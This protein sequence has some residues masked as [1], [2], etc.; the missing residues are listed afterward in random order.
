M[1]QLLLLNYLYLV[2]FYSQFIVRFIQEQFIRQEHDWI[3][4]NLNDQ[5]SSFNSVEKF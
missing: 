5:K 2:G 3:T 4:E 1:A